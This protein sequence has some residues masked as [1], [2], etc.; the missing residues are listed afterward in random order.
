MDE[1][2]IRAPH[3]VLETAGDQKYRS[4]KSRHCWCILGK[5]NL[6]KQIKNNKH[7]IIT[8]NSTSFIWEVG[9]AFLGNCISV[10]NLSYKESKKVKGALGEE[11][12]KFQRLWTSLEAEQGVDLD[13]SKGHH[14]K[15]YPGKGHCNKGHRGT[16]LSQKPASSFVNVQ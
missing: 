12:G 1:L 6:I 13:H 4:Q 9:G 7:I 5:Y 3:H 15:G 16:G 10:T 2:I 14:G 11:M 8:C